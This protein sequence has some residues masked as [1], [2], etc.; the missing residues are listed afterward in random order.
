MSVNTRDR[1]LAEAER[2]FGQQGFA[3]TRLASIAS[4]AGLGNAGL[5]H[6][7]RSKATL[8]RAVL[9]DIASD[10]SRC[11]VVNDDSADAV[12]KLDALITGLL[13]LHRDRPNAMA[14]I[15]H[16]FLDQSGRIES[17]EFL[18]LASVVRDTVSILEAGQR[19][20]TVRMGD[21]IAM[22]AALH[23]VLIIGCLGRT[24]YRRTGGVLPSDKDSSDAWET[25]LARS[26]RASVL[27]T[28]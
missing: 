2:L 12:S 25:E 23:G 1:I 24:V 22:A 3:A 10:L 18:P 21:P 27:L 5:L 15:A 20:G 4:A 26:A 6:Y 8:Y 19:V 17:A 28:S 14:I 16:E 13:S 9:D 7:F 11:Y